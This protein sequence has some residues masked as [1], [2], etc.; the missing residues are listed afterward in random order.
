MLRSEGVKCQRLS[1]F[2][3]PYSP[4][5]HVF[6]ILQSLFM[7]FGQHSG[8]HAKFVSIKICSPMGASQIHTLSVEILGLGMG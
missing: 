6:I 8:C 7:D 2:C 5:V 1:A 4:R 3:M